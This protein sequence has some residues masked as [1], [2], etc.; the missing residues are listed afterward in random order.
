MVYTD[1]A[2]DGVVA[3]QDGGWDGITDDSKSDWINASYAG[4]LAKAQGTDYAPEG[5]SLTADHTN[6][7]FTIG[8]GTAFIELQQNVDYRNYDDSEIVRS[9]VWED[10]FL[11]LYR[12][13]TTQTL[14]FETT[15]DVNYVWVFYKYPG[16]NSDGQ[17]DTHIRI[18]TDK[19]ADDPSNT[20]SNPSLLI[21][22]ADAANDT[23]ATEK[24]RVAGYSW[25]FLGK[26]DSG[27]SFISEL[28]FTVPDNS[29]DEYKVKLIGVIGDG[30]SSGTEFRGRI[31][32]HNGNYT[33][34]TTQS[35]TTGASYIRLAQVRPDR[36]SI[37]GTLYVSVDG[38][39]MTFDN[40]LTSNQAK[41][42]A[43]S[44][45]N[46]SPPD[47]TPI[48]SVQLYFSSGSIRG[49]VNF[50]GRNTL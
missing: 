36:I 5:F 24:N 41:Q 18:G 27:G 49:E 26:R 39:F 44:G 38:G 8:K 2:V 9:R 34:R 23:V 22:Q 45:G 13:A 47:T 37:N 6:E 46:S 42:Y 32:N 1:Y 15:S 33:Y 50:W 40:R 30:T 11:T 31:N 16:Q 35:N 19:S 3:P 17:N 43:F 48:N 28:D 29:Y 25:N 12:L 4:A 7:E 20:D 14:S 21:G 10:G